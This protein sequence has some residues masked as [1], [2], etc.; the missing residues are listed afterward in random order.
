[1][2]VEAKS[3]QRRAARG[4][5]GRALHPSPQAS[6]RQRPRMGIENEA[7]LLSTCHAR[8]I[9]LLK[10]NLSKSG[11]LAAT[12]SERSSK[13]GYASVFG[14]DAAICAIGMLLSGDG[15]LEREAVTT[16]HTLAV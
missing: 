4:R 12:I 16:L 13:R 7:E 10:R 9:E 2:T 6:T 5:S 8:A 1:M 15:V 11:I 14:R 3:G